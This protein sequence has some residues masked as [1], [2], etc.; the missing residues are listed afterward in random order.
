MPTKAQRA[1]ALKHGGLTRAQV[2]RELGITPQRVAQLLADAERRR[3]WEDDCDEEARV[4]V[5]DREIYY[6][7]DLSS[8]VRMT[9]AAFGT[10]QGV[11]RWDHRQWGLPPTAI[12]RT[13][14]HL[15]E[16]TALDLLKLYN[17][18]RKALDTVQRFLDSEGLH[19]KPSPAM[20]SSRVYH[21]FVTCP[22]CQGTG[23]RRV[24]RRELV[25][26]PADEPTPW[27][28]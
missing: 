4:P 21:A 6:V 26:P 15:V 2:A 3:A 14:R 9:L 5:L 28:S 12:I 19:L 25:D 11:E 13:V 27:R 8:H 18:G 20:P 22:Y 10:P 17:F 24:Q 7:R 1:A 23:Q 16:W